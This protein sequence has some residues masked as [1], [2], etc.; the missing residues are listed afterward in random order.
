MAIN[1]TYCELSLTNL[2]CNTEASITSL[3]ISIS[4]A[5]NNSNNNSNNNNNNNN[6]NDN[7][8]KNNNNSNNN[9]KVLIIRKIIIKE[10][11]E[12]KFYS[13][14]FFKTSFLQLW[15]N[16]VVVLKMFNLLLNLFKTDGPLNEILFWHN[17]L[18]FSKV[19]ISKAICY[20]VFY[21]FWDGAIGSFPKNGKVLFQYL[22]L[23]VAMRCSTL[24]Y[25]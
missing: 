3:T 10:M 19:S 8:N 21:I 15:V 16:E 5:Y 25:W 4:V 1:N 13:L 12:V 7:N 18:L 9:M 6:N 24:F 22:K 23:S 2:L 20:L 14:E 17:L 11:D